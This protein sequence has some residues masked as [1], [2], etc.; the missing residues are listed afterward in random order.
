MA[1]FMIDS[2]NVRELSTWFHK[3]KCEVFSS[4]I[5]ESGK[6]AGHWEKKGNQIFTSSKIYKTKRL[7]FSLINQIKANGGKIIYQG[8]EKYTDPE[9]SNGSGLYKAVLSRTI[10]AIEKKFRPEN[11]T[12]AIIL[13][14]HNDRAKLMVS[15]QQTM[16]SRI[17]GAYGLM[18]PPY[19]V[20]SHLYPSV[21][22]ADWIASIVGSLW[23]YKTR[24][25]QF[26]D[27]QWAE[28]YFE[29]RINSAVTHSTLLRAAR[30]KQGTFAL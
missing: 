4:E 21:Q 3:L 14:Q 11:E 9:K 5:D 24:P 26:H 23:N 8:I 27:E 29:T 12:Y 28:R 15:A 6:H 10:R 17:D 30:A 13:D 25:E 18:E 1:G 7:G 2:G 22:M 19:Q 20:E 16:Y